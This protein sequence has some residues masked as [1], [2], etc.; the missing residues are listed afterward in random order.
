ML[1][2]HELL[3]IALFNF[4]PCWAP[5]AL[6]YDE[7]WVQSAGIL[8]LTGFSRCIDICVLQSFC[9]YCGLSK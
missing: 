7:G 6:R 2:L 8:E 4:A 3:C 9:T 1:Q 5:V